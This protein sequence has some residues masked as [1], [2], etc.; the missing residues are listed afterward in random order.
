MSAELE[1][2]HNSTPE[3]EDQEVYHYAYSG[4]R[5]QHGFVP[6]WLKLVTLGLIIW[7]VYYLIRY[8]EPG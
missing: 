2:K 4:I 7:G 8:W 1:H 6:L 3:A 5:E